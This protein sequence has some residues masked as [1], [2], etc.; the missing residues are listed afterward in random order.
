[1]TEIDSTLDP[2][3]ESGDQG[4]SRKN[5]AR[6]S[7]DWNRH[8]SSVDFGWTA[9][10]IHEHGKSFGTPHHG[11]ALIYG[12]FGRLS[13]HPGFSYAIIAKRLCRA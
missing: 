10:L 1:M 8:L 9:S 4:T 13:V 3:V 2:F 5:R 6:N 11:C 12:V 7:H